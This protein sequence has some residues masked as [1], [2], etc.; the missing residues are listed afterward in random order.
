MTGSG[1]S[2]RR[3]SRLVSIRLDRDVLQFENL[4][5]NRPHTTTPIPAV[6]LEKLDLT[7]LKNIA[8]FSAKEHGY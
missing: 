8:F 7:P 6:F 2:P 4:F 3:L 5:R 1:I